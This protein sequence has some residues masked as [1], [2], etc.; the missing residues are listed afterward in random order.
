MKLRRIITLCI[1]LILTV[2]LL[3]AGTPAQAVSGSDYCYQY[4]PEIVENTFRFLDEIY[5]EKH[6]EMGLR[7]LS[8]TKKDQQTLATLADII[9]ASCSTD[10]QK[11][12]AIFKWVKRNI[13]Y[14]NSSQFSTDTFFYRKGNCLSMANLI[15][16][17]LR[18]EGIPA[19]VGDGFNGNMQTL[20][21]ETMQGLSSGHAWCFA[22][23]GGQWVLYD[24][25]WE[26]EGVT[27]RAYMAKWYFMDTVDQVRPIYNSRP[28]F[29]TGSQIV[30]TGGRFMHFEGYEVCTAIHSTTG[31]LLNGADYTFTVCTYPPSAD[32]NPDGWEYVE[33]PE[34]RLSMIPGEVFR[35][36]WMTHGDDFLLEY[37]YE[38]GLHPIGTVMEF[39][40][41]PYYLD[42]GKKFR[43]L[44]EE[45]QYYL[46][47]GV[48]CVEPGF[49]GRII[50]PHWYTKYKDDKGYII[51]WTSDDPS[52]ATVDQNGFVTFLKEGS[53]F[54]GMSLEDA[55][56]GGVH[57]V[58]LG[59][60]IGCHASDRVADFSDNPIYHS[61]V[62]V[63]RGSAEATCTEDGYE[64]FICSCGEVNYT[65]IPAGHSGDWQVTKDPTSSAPGLKTRTCTV[66][67]KTEQ[68]E[69][70]KLSESETAPTIPHECYFGIRQLSG[71]ICIEDVVVTLRCGICGKTT[72]G[73]II[74][75]TGH[76]YE[77]W[78]VLHEPGD[79]WSGLRM[80]RCKNCGEPQEELLPP[81]AA[82]PVDKLGYVWLEEDTAV[83]PHEALQFQLDR[84]EAE[85]LISLPLATLSDTLSGAALDGFSLESATA[86]AAALQTLLPAGT[87]HLDAAAL[88][89]VAQQAPG[90]VT[91]ELVSIDM[92]AL[93]PDQQTALAG[94]HAAAV[95][96]AS[97]F[98]QE[99]T[100]H[101]LMDGTATVSIPFI[102][103]SGTQ[104]SDYCVVYVAEDGGLTPM[105]T[106]FEEGFLIFTTDHFS[107]YAV[108]RSG[109]SGITPPTGPGDTTAPGTSPTVPSG[110]ETGENTDPDE[111]GDPGTLWIFLIL[112]AVILTGGAVAVVIFLK[113]RKAS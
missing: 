42:G 104:G 50:E 46:K 90:G 53:A 31:F 40:G 32:I 3:P 73:G 112:G 18:L 21:V 2:P 78:K 91:L 107:H 86:K 27:D 11:A 8:G 36:G 41:T 62:Y 70:P 37:V 109:D 13:A 79:T 66:C 85:C 101:D 30:Y 92:D 95:I 72:D 103:E 59:V 75:S 65:V 28:P 110:S 58:G 45:D 71:N 25:L 98:G 12:D 10:R 39:E 20:T 100:V 9:T 54:I 5:L 57:S 52:V 102:P 80:R 81:T 4:T 108:V 43:L 49:S 35:G 76:E 63:L 87:V 33:N 77:D 22:H 56:T 99:G 93:N 94:K 96:S 34:R 67:G 51:R 29:R 106:R 82:T 47:N 68:Q 14:E 83:I 17:L 26:P 19:V 15:R 97:I 105:Q 69:I 88:R 6:P 89:A 48:L 61:C 60:R 84:M 55:V 74:P 38:N 7:W 23:V 1:A 24:P 16:D 44:L 64:H 111:S 113:K